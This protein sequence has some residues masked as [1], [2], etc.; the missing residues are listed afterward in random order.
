MLGTVKV[1]DVVTLDCEEGGRYIAWVPAVPGCH[2][3]GRSRRQA[4]ARAR[5]ALRFYVDTLRTPGRKPP[6]WLRP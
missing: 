2:A 4:V 6:R 1:R 3:Y 5:A